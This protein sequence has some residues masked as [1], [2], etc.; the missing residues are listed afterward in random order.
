M[1]YDSPQ[2]LSGKTT[3]EVDP[4]QPL[5][6]P[7]SNP[8]SPSPLCVSGKTIKQMRDYWMRK[9]TK[10]RDEMRKVMSSEIRLYLD[11]FK[12]KMDGLIPARQTKN[13]VDV[14]VVYPIIKSLVPELYYRDPK[15]LIEAMDREFMFEEDAFLIGPDGNPVMG[16]DGQ[17]AP[18]PAY[19]GGKKQDVVDG[20]RA[21]ALLAG[22][23]NRNLLA[24][25]TKLEKK[26]AIQDALLC[27]YGAL[28]LGWD[29]EQGNFAMTLEGEDAPPSKNSSVQPGQAYAIRMKPWDVL[30]DDANFYKPQWVAFRWAVN[31]WD[32][33]ADK[34][35]LNT[36]QLKG[37]VSD[38]AERYLGFNDKSKG[39]SQ[40]L[41]EYFELY[42]RPCAEYPH[43]FY[44]VLTD[45]IK[46]DTL[47]TSFFPTERTT[48]LPVSLIY[49][50]EDPEGGLP[51][52]DV[53]YYIDQQRAKSNLV[54]TEYEYVKR[55]LPIL[56]VNKS[57]LDDQQK[58]SAVIQSG[59]IPK[60]LMV[61]DKPDEVAKAVTFGNLNMDFRHMHQLVDD[62]I[63]RT[64]GK[65]SGAGPAGVADVKLASVAKIGD[66]AEAVR[67]GERA[68]IVRDFA[69][70]TVSYWVALY[71]EYSGDKMAAPVDTAPG[72]FPGQDQRFP[73]QFSWKDIRGK[74]LVKIKPFSLN[75]EDPTIV[76][77]Q[78]IDRMNLMAS[79]QVTEVL[80]RDGKMYNMARDLKALIETYQDNDA[81]QLLIPYQPTPEEVMALQAQQQ[82]LAAG[83]AGVPHAPPPGVPTPPLKPGGNPGGAPIQGGAV[84]QEMMRAPMNPSAERSAA[85]LRRSSSQ[86]VVTR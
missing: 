24:A 33:K 54:N 49:F 36:E 71:Q 59:V 70:N 1:A 6:G 13:R 64:V 30:V 78:I 10:R 38:A 18:D 81:D 48:E 66:Q 56:A 20:P 32:L 3:E 16:P 42:H 17:P 11:V 74:F 52:P 72:V 22:V 8:D 60:V 73:V 80:K 51:I 41:T 9:C 45:E 29:N 83:A 15:V 53:R 23:I 35:L 61:K 58:T 7:Q 4:N 76:R 12:H 25:K 46:D 65:I 19:P 14:N 67:T 79:P 40:S 75:Y 63:S 26:R 21:A 84:S 2:N 57:L 77:R 86:P 43:G 28:K 68:D 44:M 85:L 34:R 37:N 27:P 69:I 47:Y 39:D 82:A 50:N 55:T 5:F 62:N 31:P